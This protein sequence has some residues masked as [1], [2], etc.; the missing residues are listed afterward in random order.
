MGEKE[1]MACYTITKEQEIR[2]SGTS[3]QHRNLSGTVLPHD[4]IY[5][6]IVTDFDTNLFS[7]A[8]LSAFTCLLA[9]MKVETLDFTLASS[10]SAEER[11]KFS[12]KLVHAFKTN[13]FVKLT[14]HGIPN[15]VVEE[16]FA[17][18]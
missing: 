5:Y 17:L 18:V 10:S 12:H 14:N 8:W 9:S 1:E 13:G 3:K 6:H 2:L 15:A 7:P 4:G 11:I 16:A